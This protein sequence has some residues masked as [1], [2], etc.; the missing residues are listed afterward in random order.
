DEFKPPTYNGKFKYT[1][2][3]PT[4]GQEYNSPQKSITIDY[5]FERKL[6]NEITLLDIY[7]LTSRNETIKTLIKNA[8]TTEGNHRFT[9]DF[10]DQLPCDTYIIRF[11][12]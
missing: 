1:I 7:M 9:E 8:N 2:N 6:P 4:P 3:E 12:E 11:N 10:P 5:T